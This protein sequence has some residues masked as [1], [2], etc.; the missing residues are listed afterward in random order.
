MTD[1][2][3]KGR[4][5]AV[6]F[7]TFVLMMPETL[8]VPV[9]RALVRER[10][11]VGDG[12]ASLFMT[13]NMIGALL[14]AP[15]AGSWVDARGGRRRLALFALGADALLMQAL[16]HPH[17]YATFLLLRVFEGAAHIV[18]LT[19]VMS[20]VA[21]A[22]GSARGRALG[23]LGAG[24]TLGVAAGAAI[25]G[26]IGRDDPLLTLHA[27]S[28]LLVAALG[29]AVFALPPDAPPTRRAS[30]RELLAAVRH[31][32]ELRTPLLVAAVERFTV[33][34]FTTGFPLMLAGVFRVDRPRIGMLLGAFLF[35][36]AILSWPAGLLAPKWTARRMVLAGS[37]AYGVG[38]AL[39]PF[40]PL[41][42]TW[43]LMPWLGV[44]SA[45]MFVPSMLWL[46]ERAEGIG[47]STAIASFHAAGSLGFLLGPVCC[48]TLVELGGG[49][50]HGYELAFAFAGASVL[51]S[52]LLVRRSARAG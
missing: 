51:A 14:A 39:V 13:A 36:F 48:G 35:P 7:V 23:P 45:V 27:A 2:L 37:V 21:D 17:D 26:R 19:M 24:L 40:A 33:G 8:P 50:M 25:G 42:W 30:A 28:L 38:V 20:L 22:A 49:A 46:L 31:R 47:R 4:I 34:F 29:L 3:T 18:A 6:A 43:A 12:L 32:P 44:C 5:A 16:A 41:P 52:A 11:G 1:A 9:L 10:F 15:L